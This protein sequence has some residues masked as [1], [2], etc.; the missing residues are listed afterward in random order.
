LP[1]QQLYDRKSHF[2]AQ[3]QIDQS[4]VELFSLRQLQGIGQVADSYGPKSAFLHLGHA[5]SGNEVLVFEDEDRGHRTCSR[6][7]I[8]SLQS[9]HTLATWSCITNAKEVV[10]LPL[11]SFC[12]RLKQPRGRR[13]PRMRGTRLDDRPRRSQAQDRAFDIARRDPPP[14][15]SRKAAAVVIAEVLEPIGDTCPECPPD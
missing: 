11:G 6:M 13:H 2:S 4:A 10:G 14:G 8:G 7:R 3:I 15:I 9:L 5:V 1:A 12:K